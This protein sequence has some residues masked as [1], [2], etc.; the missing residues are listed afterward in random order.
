MSRYVALL[1][2]INVGGNNLIKMTALKAC[3][4]AQGYRNVTTFIQTGNVLFDAKESGAA[5]VRP[6]EAMLAATFKVPI[7]VVLRNRKQMRDIVAGAPAGFGTQPD[8]YRSDVIFLM[9]PLKAPAVLAAVPTKAGVD[10]AYVGRGVLYVSRL[11]ARATQSQLSRIITLPVYKSMTI[12]NW[13][14]TTKLLQMLEA[15]GAE[16]T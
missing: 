11:I 12:R 6:I 10:Q 1:R 9:P 8:K 4:E 5:L 2:G 16:S 15:A 7:T 13:N 3:F 14:T